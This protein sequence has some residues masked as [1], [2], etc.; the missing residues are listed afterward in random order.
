MKIQDLKIPT[1]SLPQALALGVCLLTLGCG[2]SA[3]PVRKDV[4]SARRQSP[5][6]FIQSTALN[7]LRTSSPGAPLFESL[8]VEQTGVAFVNPLLIDHPLNALN[9]SGFVCGGVCIG[10]INGDGRPD[11]YLISGSGRNRLYLQSGDVQ[12]TDATDA[13]GV[14]G[15]EAWGAGGRWWISTT[16]EIW[17][18]TCATTTHRINFTSTT[19]LAGASWNRPGNTGLMWWIR[20]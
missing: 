7:A 11:L 1:A 3:K 14:D 12:F 8:S 6:P 17:T 4:D 2:E 16:T 9:G 13:T 20:A 5:E 10:D 15:G 19:A 18:F